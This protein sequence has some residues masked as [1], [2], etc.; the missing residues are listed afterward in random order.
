MMAAKIAEYISNIRS[1]LKVLFVEVRSH[2][3][4][5]P[6]LQKPGCHVLQSIL[7][8]TRMIRKAFRCCGMTELPV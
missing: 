8:R 7:H 2:S 5:S 6:L 1:L 3:V 4:R